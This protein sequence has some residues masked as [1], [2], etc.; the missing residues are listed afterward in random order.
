MGTWTMGKF[1]RYK[2]VCACYGMRASTF[3]FQSQLEVQFHAQCVLAASIVQQLD[4]GLLH[5]QAP[6]M[7]GQQSQGRKGG[8]REEERNKGG[9]R[10]E[11]GRKGGREEEG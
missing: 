10:D 7:R 8:T 5:L 6:H 4:G 1:E 2:S 3:R 11:Q 9:A